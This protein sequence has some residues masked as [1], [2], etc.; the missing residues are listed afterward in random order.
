MS[1]ALELGLL[2][3]SRLR[4]AFMDEFHYVDALFLKAR[5]SLANLSQALADF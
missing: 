5:E 4:D 1:D 3:G 2:V